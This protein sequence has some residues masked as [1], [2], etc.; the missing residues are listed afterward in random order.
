MYC[1]KCGKQIDDEA[2]VCIYCGVS[3]KNM[4]QVKDN[5]IIINNSSSASAASSSTASGPIRK[6]HSLLFDIVMIFLTCGLWLIWMLIRPKY[7]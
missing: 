1:H 3:T 4:Q 7:Y 2:V 5:P 6:K